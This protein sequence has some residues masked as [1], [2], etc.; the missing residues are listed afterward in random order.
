[1]HA[2]VDRVKLTEFEKV[3]NKIFVTPFPSKRL[4][5]PFEFMGEDHEKECFSPGLDGFQTPTHPST[6]FSYAI[7]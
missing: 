2:Q 1:M 3:D 6:F 4:F 5:F 7:K